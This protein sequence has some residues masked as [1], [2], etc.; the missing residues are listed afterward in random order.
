MTTVITIGYRQFAI[1]KATDAAA[2]VRIMAEAVPIDSAYRDGRTWFFPAKD[3]DRNK[4]SMEVVPDRQVL[5]T[6]PPA[7]GDIEAATTVP[8][9]RGLRLIGPSIKTPSTKEAA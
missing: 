3:G 4:I 1:R 6:E 2:L 7:E 8:R 9:R 5:H